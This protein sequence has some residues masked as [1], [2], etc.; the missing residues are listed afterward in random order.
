MVKGMKPLKDEIEN[1]SAKSY[2]MKLKNI[3]SVLSG[4][5]DSRQSKEYLVKELEYEELLNNPQY[6]KCEDFWNSY[7]D[8]LLVKYLQTLFGNDRYF[9]CA[10]D[11][12]RVMFGLK[13]A[14]KYP[15]KPKYERYIA[16]YRETRNPVLGE[17]TEESSMMSQVGKIEREIIEEL[18]KVI[19]KDIFE[20]SDGKKLNLLETDTYFKKDIDG[21]AINMPKKDIEDDPVANYVTKIRF[22]E[23]HDDVAEG[24]YKALCGQGKSPYDKWVATWILKCIRKKFKKTI[25]DD[26]M[27]AAFALLPGYE[28]DGKDGLEQR[29]SKYLEQ[30]EY[31]EIYPCESYRK[32]I[33]GTEESIQVM[34]ELKELEMKITNRLIQYIESIPE[35]DRRGHIEN[36]ADYGTYR[37]KTNSYEITKQHL[38]FRKNRRL[39][40]RVMTAGVSVIFLALNIIAVALQNKNVPPITGNPTIQNEYPSI[41]DG[42]PTIDKNLDIASNEP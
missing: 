1:I 17:L 36:L 27:L 31:L 2:N 30:S 26:I 40:L 14:S 21:N 9:N 5:R 12:M 20:K 15:T 22:S 35:K 23:H 34:A 4:A 18:A 16:Y 6:K 33:T 25:H 13:G 41:E 3:I 24:L 38:H 7:T 8:R 42:R 28:L 19:T 37:P 10:L 11:F 32:N 39:F 29:L